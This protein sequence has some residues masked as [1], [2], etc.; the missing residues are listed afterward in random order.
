MKLRNQQGIGLADPVRDFRAAVLNELGNAPEQIEPGQLHRFPTNDRRSDTAGWCILFADLRAGAYG[1]HR[2]GIRKNWKAIVDQFESS[3]RRIEL[4]TKV[5]QATRERSRKRHAKWSQNEKRNSERWSQCQALHPDCPATFYLQHRGIPSAKPLPDCLRFH[6]ALP[7]W[8]EGE[9]LGLFAAMVAPLVDHNGKVVALHQTF[10]T[11][12]G[13]K[14]DLPIV[15]KL[16]RTAGPIE[17]TCIP[18]FKP[19]RGCIGIAEGIET[20]LAASC[21]TG[22]PT[23][24]A[25]CANNLATYRWPSG[26]RQ[27]VIFADA[28]KAGRAAAYKLRNRA[29]KAGLRVEIMLPATEGADWCDVLAEQDAVILEAKG[30]A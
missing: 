3:K 8:H 18:L 25:Y 22:V 30:V 16:T 10:I 4:A 14:A 9:N 17:G 21:E 13:R 24:A 29:L 23:V 11:A 2:R 6:P 1:C 20:A 19:E 7:Y 28:D 27:L 12:D 26:V 15:K 5:E